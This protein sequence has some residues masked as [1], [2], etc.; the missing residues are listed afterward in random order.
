MRPIVFIKYFFI[1]LLIAGSIFLSRSHTEKVLKYSG[2]KIYWFIPDG[3]RSEPI[4]FKI[5]EWARAGEL[6]NL[7]Y[8]IENGSSGYS[9]PVFPS[10]T[11]TNFATL[12][13]GTTPDIHGIADGAMR[14]SGYPIKMVSRGGFSSG[15]RLVPSIWDTT[16]KNNLQTSMISVPGSTPPTVQSGE[17]I[18]GRWGNWGVDFPAIIFQSQNDEFVKA[19]L[20]QNKRVF[21]F[22]SDLTRFIS[23][24]K[25]N[26]WSKN[27]YK[28]EKPLYEINLSNWGFKL[29]GLA[30]ENYEILISRDKIN[31]LTRLK[32]SDWSEWLS[33]DLKWNAKSDY[34]I[35]T[36]KKSELE[37]DLSSLELQTQ[38]KVNLIFVN[39]KTIRIRIIYNSLNE[40]LAYP[41]FLAEKLTATI[42]PMTDFVD[43]YPPQLI[44]YKEDKKTFLEEMNMSFEWHRK[45][46]HEM[47]QNSNS[48][49]IIQSIYSPNQMLTSRWW[50]PYLDPRSPMYKL[51]GEEERNLLW[52]E[53]KSMYKK[54]DLILGEV[55]KEPSIGTIVFSSDHGVAPLY[56]EVRLNNL[57]AKKGWLKFSYSTKLDQFV[58]DWENSK[59]VFLQMH[60]IYINP[61]GLGGNLSH[62]TDKKYKD[63]REEVIKVLKELEDKD[64]KTKVVELVL[65]NEEAAQLHLPADRVGDLIVA[66][67]FLYCFTEDTSKDLGVFK[68][69]LK[70]GYKQA[71]LPENEPALLTPFVIYGKNIKKNFVLTKTIDHVDQYQ[72]IMHLLKMPVGNY[73]K[74]H[75]LDDVFIK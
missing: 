24:D 7:K 39:D 59:V 48:N 11:P 21:T 23:L 28:N 57:F 45:A 71:I 53:V 6:P 8:L 38:F 1:F 10:H 41:D 56:K 3:L 15:S 73:T 72:T 70:G 19:E 68:D 22:G 26:N 14:I 37:N 16:E 61:D 63:L 52:A 30:L 35:N 20:G 25:P 17:V 33:A 34:N 44:F 27:L 40:F 60:N 66:N 46:V 67:A 62:R 18:R 31:L 51:I 12:T 75:V 47:V 36:P 64:T 2:D 29:Y 50:M 54:I 5:Y 13:T 58:I 69:S 74:G 32:K 43:N 4:T 9:R 49:L 42:G 65:K 55:L